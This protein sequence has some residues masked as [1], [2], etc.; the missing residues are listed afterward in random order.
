[1][2]TRHHVGGWPKKKSS[3]VVCKEVYVMPKK[4]I[5]RVLGA[6][7]RKI[8]EHRGLTQ[9]EVA[10]FIGVGARQ[11]GRI[12]RGTQSITADRLGLLG[13]HLSVSIADFLDGVD[14]K[15]EELS[16]HFQRS[17]LKMANHELLD[18]TEDIETL[19]I[20]NHILVRHNARKQGRS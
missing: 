1:M 20:V 15:S 7:I 3:N 11:Y 2:K 17:K 18:D 12:E 4:S 8:R 9:D 6:N 16:N 13:K 19:R 14:D 5:S 10:H